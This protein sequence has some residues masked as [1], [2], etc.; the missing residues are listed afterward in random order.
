MNRKAYT[1]GY[2]KNADG[3][4]SKPGFKKAMTETLVEVLRPEIGKINQTAA[5]M[6]ADISGVKQFIVPVEPVGAPR[7]TQRDKWKKRPCVLRYFAFRDAV[8]KAVG[9]I[10]SVP[11]RVDCIFYFAMP[12]SWSKK[13]QA[14]FVGLPHRVKPDRDNC[15]KAICDS[16][17]EEDS[18]IHE[19]SQIKR[20]CWPGQERVVIKLTYQKP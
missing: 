19:G 20:W 14:K 8:R 10:A 17:F 5:S 9:P 12:K 2:T 7:M 13:K 18:A 3:T 4:F 6:L 16:L 1:D 11:D 15:D